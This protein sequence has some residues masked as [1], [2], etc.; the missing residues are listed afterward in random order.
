MTATDCLML[1]A[2]HAILDEHHRRFQLL[3]EQ[4]RLDEAMMQ[5]RITVQCA[6]D[7][8]VDA[9]NLVDEILETHRKTN[10]PTPPAA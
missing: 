1:D 9:L 10:L 6:N 5:F 3:H 8:L 4:G 7:V 2:K